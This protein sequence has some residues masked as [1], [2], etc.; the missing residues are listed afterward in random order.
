V[1]PQEK[2]ERGKADISGGV[3]NVKKKTWGK[4]GGGLTWPL[5]PKGL[6]GGKKKTEKGAMGRGVKVRGLEPLGSGKT[7]ELSVKSKKRVIVK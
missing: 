1:A 7:G 3:E 2:K 4:R 6:I 5:M